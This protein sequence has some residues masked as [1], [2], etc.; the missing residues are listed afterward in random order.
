M[1]DEWCNGK[2]EMWDRLY[3]EKGDGKPQVGQRTSRPM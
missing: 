1:A 2:A 3:M